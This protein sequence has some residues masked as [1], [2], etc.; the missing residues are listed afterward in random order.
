MEN[1]AGRQWKS[2][3]QQ[4]ATIKSHTRQQLFC[5]CVQAEARLLLDRL[6]GLGEGGAG[7]AARKVEQ[8][9]R[10]GRWRGAGRGRG[11]LWQWPADK[12]VASI[13]L[14]GNFQY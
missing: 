9:R 3:R 4:L 13:G 6:K 5:V 14:D 11:E 1:Q 7:E 8:G 12:K 2:D 10:P